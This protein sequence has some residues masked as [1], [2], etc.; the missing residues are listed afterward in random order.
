MLNNDAVS[1]YQIGEHDK[2][3]Q[4]LSAGLELVISTLSNDECH[5][6]TSHAL[7]TENQLI[8]TKN[9]IPTDTLGFYARRPKHRVTGIEHAE[10]MYDA[11]FIFT[12]DIPVEVQDTAIVLLFNTALIRH[13]IGMHSKKLSY[14]HNSHVLYSKCLSLFSRIYDGENEEGM[15]FSISLMIIKAAACVNMLHLFQ[16]GIN[17]VTMDPPRNIVSRFH[18]AMIQLHSHPKAWL[19]MSKPDQHFFS[20]EL[21]MTMNSPMNIRSAQAA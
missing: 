7:F 3:H 20:V 2:A 4:K 18:L 21:F 14:F 10:P 6:K 9:K 8:N 13:K 15:P 5:E 16:Y 17:P 19:F 11:C 12:D 1:Y